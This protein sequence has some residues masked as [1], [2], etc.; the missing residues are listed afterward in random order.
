M[1]GL[2]QGRTRGA[3]NQ[4]RALRA[5]RWPAA[6]MALALLGG[7]AAMDAASRPSLDAV[8]AAMPR[9]IAGF[10]RGDIAP[11][12]GPTLS[13]DYATANRAAVATVLVYE[14]GGR[15]PS[16]PGA[17]EIDREVT[18]AVAEVTEAPS[19]RTGRRLTEHERV[20]IA[21]PGMRCAL[22]QGAFGR[23]PVTRHVCVGTAEGRFVKMQITMS[24]R[25]AASVDAKAFAAGALRAVRGA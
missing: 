18:S 10:V 24:D 11:R 21:D 9:E 22:L 12:S 3:A 16:D 25:L 8:A 15:V 2:T 19:G 20:T 7:C 17:A 6:A 13:L 1:T 14:T 4:A 23:A 5:P